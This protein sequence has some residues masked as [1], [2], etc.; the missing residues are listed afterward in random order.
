MKGPGSRFSHLAIL[1]LVTVPG[2][3]EILKPDIWIE[4]DAYLN[5][6]LLLGRGELPYRDF[7][8]QHFP[9]LE[10]FTAAVLRVFGT[11]ILTAELLTATATVLVSFLVFLLGKRLG[12]PLC[13]TAAA[14]VYAYSPLLQRFHLFHREIFLMVPVLIAVLLLDTTDPSGHRSL[15]A[16]FFLGTAILIKAT[17]VAYLAAAV[18]FLLFFRPCRP[19]SALTVAG[20]AAA[21]VGA[22]TL[23][24]W[25]L[26]GSDFL[27]QVFIFAASVPAFDSWG[28]RWAQLTQD[29]G[30]HFL[31]ALLGI[32]AVGLRRQWRRWTPILVLGAFSFL[33]VAVLKP[34]VWAHNNLELLPWLALATGFLV[35]SA[36]R[37]ITRRLRGR[38]GSKFVGAASMTLI[39]L[40]VWFGNNLTGIEEPGVQRLIS[41]EEIGIMAAVLRSST[42]PDDLVFVPSIVAFE[43]DRK[44]LIPSIEIAGWVKDLTEDCR[45]RSLGDVLEIVDLWRHR[46]YFDVVDRSILSSVKL[47]E[48]AIRGHRVAAVFS[49]VPGRPS[50]ISNIL[51]APRFLFE[52]GYVPAVTTEH[53][54]LW[55]LSRYPPKFRTSL[56]TPLS[57][58]PAS[59]PRGSDPVRRPF[60][61]TGASPF[62]PAPRLGAT[63]HKAHKVNQTLLRSLRCQ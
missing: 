41:R 61:E 29:T 33:F 27:I 54:V 17:A 45:G 57:R 26:F 24:L 21:V 8:L 20:T 16:G 34:I 7:V 11:S 37:S 60:R 39:G 36:D 52:S 59:A 28:L 31:P 3:L 53:Y 22:A 55:T 19:R 10:A 62:A 18:S 35:D 40:A 4:D 58:S 48:S 1:A 13:G 32:V 12:G 38:A 6:A 25:L 14:V 30:V 15:A 9:L 44:E 43:A 46:P 42:A 56:S 50:P 63:C 23:G 47:A 49:V 51:L 5:C 2:I